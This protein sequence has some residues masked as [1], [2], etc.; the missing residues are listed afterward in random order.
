MR[1][2]RVFLK[3]I[4]AGPIL[5]ACE[6]VLLIIV[7]LMGITIT[8]IDWCFD[9]VLPNIA[10]LALRITTMAHNLPSKEWYLK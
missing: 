5:C 6:I 2:L 4:I 9:N 1:K 3:L 7:A 10:K 8:F